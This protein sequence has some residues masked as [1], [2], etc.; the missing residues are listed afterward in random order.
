MPAGSVQDRNTEHDSNISKPDSARYTE[1]LLYEWCKST[2]SHFWNISSV[3]K[4]SCLIY[5][6]SMVRVHDVPFAIAVICF[7]Q[8][9]FDGVSPSG[10]AWDFGSHIISSNLITPVHLSDSVVNNGR[11][12]TQTGLFEGTTCGKH[13]NKDTT[14]NKH[15]Y[16]DFLPSISS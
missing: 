8:R 11:H 6:V 14:A 12:C 15:L 7:S 1:S 10:K 16:S 4:S 2:V 9:C 3:G 5:S 13:L